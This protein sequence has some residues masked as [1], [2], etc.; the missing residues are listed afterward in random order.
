MKNVYA[1]IVI[2]A[3][4]IGFNA[5]SDNPNNNPIASDNNLTHSPAFITTWE[6]NLTYIKDEEYNSLPNLSPHLSNSDNN[7]Q[8]FIS[9]DGEQGNFSVD[10]GDGI[11]ENNQTSAVT[12]IYGSAGIYTV[13]MTR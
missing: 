9:T 4:F 8:I 11:V 13:K 5:C 10:W 1:I 2:F 6:T 3:T 7:H 12:H